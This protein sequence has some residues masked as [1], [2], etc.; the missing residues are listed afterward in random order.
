MGLL[1]G[2]LLV[3]FVIG[4][5]L[6][7]VIVLMQDE[8]GEGLGGIFGGGSSTPF[9]SRSGNVLT[10][11]TSILGAFFLFCAFG[12]AWLNKTPSAGDVLGAAKRGASQTQT[13]NEWWNVPA[14]TTG[15]TQPAA[16][17]TGT[18]SAAGAAAGGGATSSSAGT[19]GG[20][21]STGAATSTSGSTSGTQSGSS[22]GATGSSAP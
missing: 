6:L 12:L 14:N 20:A 15:T 3:L 16:G 18:S 21:S 8:Q 11:F 1:S 5:L 10:K 22:T 4:S 17:A 19:S 9:G 2:F 13:T 7:I